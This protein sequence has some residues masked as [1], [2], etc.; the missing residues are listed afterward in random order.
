[1]DPDG[2]KLAD[3]TDP[4]DLLVRRE[5]DSRRFPTLVKSSR[6]WAVFLLKL[7]TLKATPIPAQFTVASSRP[8]LAYTRKK[9][10]NFWNR[11]RNRP[12]V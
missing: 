8:N 5:E 3:P 7:K 2:P 6:E 9:K 11:N 1:M 4:K 10:W 12:W